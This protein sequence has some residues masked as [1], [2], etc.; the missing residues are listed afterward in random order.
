VLFRSLRISGIVILEVALS[1]TGEVGPIAVVKSIGPAI[2]MAAVDAVRK[3]KF[4]P[5]KRGDQAVPVL[6][7]LTL[8]FKLT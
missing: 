6:F 2:D 4:T 3:W 8:N 5:A 7:M 1:E